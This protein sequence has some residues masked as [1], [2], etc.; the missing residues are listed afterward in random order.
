MRAL[1]LKRTMIEIRRGEANDCEVL[2]SIDSSMDADP[3][4]GKF[5]EM[6]LAA[7]TVYVALI[8]DKIVAYSV[9][10]NSF[11]RRPTIEMLMVSLA[12]RR[13]GVGREL[14]RYAL[15]QQKIELWATTNE[16]NV[17]MQSLLEK[18]SFEKV[19]RIKGLDPGDPELVYVNKIV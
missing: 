12:V 15:S 4:R 14:V 10:N 9:V 11:F 2:K 13:H 19:G 17:P 7:G 5:I 18:E 6:E 8:R 16:S 1:C 3:K